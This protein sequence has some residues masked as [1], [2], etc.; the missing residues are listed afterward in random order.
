MDNVAGNETTINVQMSPLRFGKGR[1]GRKLGTLS[2]RYARVLDSSLRG[3][4]LAWTKAALAPRPPS[5]VIFIPL[6]VA[7]TLFMA[8]VVGLTFAQISGDLSGALRG[9][10]LVIA[11]L[12]IA[13]L[14]AIV[15][16]LVIPYRVFTSSSVSV[17]LLTSYAPYVIG[18]STGIAGALWLGKLLPFSYDSPASLWT[19]TVAVGGPVTWLLVGVLSNH[20]AAIVDRRREYEKGL[21]ELRESQERIMLVHEQTRKEIA[22]LL[23]G[24]VQSRLVVLGHWLKE[25]Q[26]RLKDGPKELAESIENANKLLQEIRDQDLRSI[27]RQLYPSI[28][29]TGLPSALNSL[30]DRFRTV[31]AV[32]L[33]L[34]QEIAELERPQKPSLNESLRLTLYRVTEEA[35]SNVAKHSHAR[36]VRVSLSLSPSREVHLTIRDNGQGFEPSEV[37]PG[38][39]LLSMEDYVT[40][41]G[42]TV[43]VKSS[44]GLGT[45]V[46]AS[47]PVSCTQSSSQGLTF[48]KASPSSEELNVAP[49]GRVRDHVIAGSRVFTSL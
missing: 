30:A 23:H 33:E 44:L 36:E 46:A 11:S 15:L 13:L 27:T 4:I 39:G 24:R 28:I 37:S 38:H 16:S 48:S 42:G 34:D 10:L 18:S 29:R 40:A 21:E 35:L 5:L 1:S 9:C 26:E 41:L 19:W 7:V 8:L 22:G 32:E 6:A 43:E 2:A 31:F 20:L 14:A 3:Q 47:V 17:A 12:P 45:L 25:C 49:D